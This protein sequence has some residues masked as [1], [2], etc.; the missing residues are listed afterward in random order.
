MGEK[1]TKQECFEVLERYRHWNTGQKSTNHA[2]N[3]ERTTEDDIFDARREL[4]LAAT[5]RLTELC[6]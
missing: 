1:M 6:A 5:K 2:F 3:G 4:I